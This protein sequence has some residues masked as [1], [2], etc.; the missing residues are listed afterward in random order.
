MKHRTFPLY[1][2][3][4]PFSWIYG[5]IIYIRNLLFNYD[6]LHSQ[7]F[8]I[9]IICV[10]N[11]TIGGTGKTPHTEYL[12][13]LLKETCSVAVLSRGYRRKSKG[14]VLANIHTTAKDLGDEP[15]QIYSKF[16]Q[17]IT[18][19]VDKKRCRGITR[20]LTI[21]PTPKPRV[22]LLDDAYQHRYVQAG[23][24]CLLTNYHRLIYDDRLL[25]VGRL[26]EPFKEKKRAQLIIVTKCPSDLSEHE[27]DTIKE[28]LHLLPYQ[29]LYF[30]TF[31][32]N[33]P[34]Q[35]TS[36]KNMDL[37]SLLSQN[38]ILLLTGIATPES[39]QNDIK[40]NALSLMCLTF[41]D[42]HLFTLQD[43]KRISQAYGLL[44]QRGKAVILTTEKDASRLLTL[45]DLTDTLKEH[46]YVL[47]IEVDFL[48]GRVD[49]HSKILNYVHQY[50][51]NS[52]VVTKATN[53]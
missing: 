4:I 41:P 31:R 19:A 53:Q 6:F 23:L 36:K 8:K 30:S 34:Y 42:H 27:M 7:S 17:S 28:K 26:R 39:L 13:R 51:K 29:S 49:F 5:G 33:S 11:L 22:I 24:T 37:E 10:G 38:H 35:L 52:C 32:Y 46:I 21:L 48:K 50:S 16:G 45:T 25:P 12:I 14:F 43:L 2:G 47:P 18:I 15:F 3:L 44:C 1:W 40:K 9:P 20:L